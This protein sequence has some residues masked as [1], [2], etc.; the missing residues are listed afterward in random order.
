MIG[1][2]ECG[3]EAVGCAGRGGSNWSRGKCLVAIDVVITVLYQLVVIVHERVDVHST[4]RCRPL[5]LS[6]VWSI[7]AARQKQRVGAPP[8]VPSITQKMY[9]C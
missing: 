4:Q 5:H 9:L 7:A 6:F 3:G 1:V 2:C 8:T